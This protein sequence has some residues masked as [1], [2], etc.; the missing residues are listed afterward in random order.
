MIRM[1]GS[2]PTPILVI[3][4]PRLDASTA[5]AFRR[6]AEHSLPGGPRLLIDLAQVE[7]MDSTGLGAVLAVF[8][9]AKAG[10]CRVRLCRPGHAVS[11]L[12]ELVRIE[13]MIP[14]HQTR[15]EA[16]TAIWE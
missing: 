3:D 8:R 6:E 10:G 11:I 4:L 9:T 13:R 15:E 2:K 12:F 14:V 16:L 7:F 1:E 5:A